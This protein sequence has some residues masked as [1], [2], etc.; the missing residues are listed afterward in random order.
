MTLF[1]SIFEQRT[2]TGRI[3]DNSPYDL[4]RQ[5]CVNSIPPIS[6]ISNDP[7]WAHFLYNCNEYYLVGI[8]TTY[9]DNFLA[10]L[11]CKL[12]GSLRWYTQCA[13]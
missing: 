5:L 2:C 9:K 3:L 1:N 8:L 13:L 10:S 4:L 6:T 7:K 11:Y 12:H